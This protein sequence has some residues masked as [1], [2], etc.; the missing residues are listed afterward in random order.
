MAE[1]AID[2]TSASF[3]EQV[4]KASHEVP[5][6]VDFWAPWCGPCRALTPVL[7]KLA[8]EYGGKFRLAKVNSDEEPA[9]AAQ[10]GVRGIPNVK[11]FVGGR[12]VD[13]F[14][15]ALP[16]SEVRRFLD[17]LLPTP[18]ELERRRALAALAAG[19]TEEAVAILAATLELAPDDDTVRADLAGALVE[20]GRLDEA[21]RAMASIRPHIDRDGTMEQL[22]TRI[23]ALRARASGPDARDLL[24][25]IEADGT[26]LDARFAFANRLVAD[27]DYA[28]ALAQL[29]EI[30]RQNRAW[31]D[32]AARKL[33]VSIFQFAQDDPDLVSR[34]RRELA[35]L[36]H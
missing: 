31:R 22:R 13:E 10:F 32:D 9:L 26:D 15:G 6:L 14:T 12:L 3:E 4:L 33:M 36:L 21:E 27:R 7:E 8:A 35:G 5:I 18:A 17:S 23:A 16:A 2:V 29:L 1:H 25:A 28:G 34:Y 19:Q 20:A 30:V 24:R 11:A